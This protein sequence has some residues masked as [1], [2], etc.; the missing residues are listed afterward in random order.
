M[1]EA[2][3]LLGSN[4]GNRKKT[5]D[6]AIEKI[7][8]QAGKVTLASSV[9]ETEPWGT[10]APPPF[11][12]QIVVIKTPLTA[13]RLLPVLL[14]I[15]NDL[16]RVRTEIKNSPRTIDIDILFFNNEIISEK[17]L[18]VP[19]PRLHLRRFVLVPLSEIVPAYCH[20]VKKKSLSQLLEE[21]PDNRWVKKLEN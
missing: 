3:L 5:I 7:N 18:E 6:S 11:Y 17:D 14:G 13:E 10:N 19:H 16:G 8:E 9:Y 1:N 21:C 4:L 2:Y 15:E 20:P 12:N